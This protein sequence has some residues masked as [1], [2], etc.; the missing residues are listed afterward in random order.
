[1]F[2][3]LRMATKT[4]NLTAGWMTQN[5]PQFTIVSIGETLT[6]SYK[7]SW[8]IDRSRNLD[9]CQNLSRIS[10]DRSI[11]KHYHDFVTSDSLIDSGSIWYQPTDGFMAPFWFKFNHWLADT[12]RIPIQS[13]TSRN[14][15][16]IVGSFVTK[17]W[18]MQKPYKFSWPIDRSVTKSWSIPK[19]YQDFVTD[20]YHL[21]WFRDIFGWFR[22]HFGISQRNLDRCQNL[23]RFRDQSNHR[24]RI[25]DRC[26]NIRISWPND[27]IWGW[28]W[29]LDHT[30]IFWGET[31]SD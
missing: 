2:H 12:K 17:P 3:A 6:K 18:S 27:T 11:P 4:T 22:L 5:G 8:P 21:S 23:I 13:K 10:C 19:P 26:Q 7:T 30:L 28:L 24:S 31:I 16:K 9:R 14:H 29:S 20:R 25:L 15:D 1:M